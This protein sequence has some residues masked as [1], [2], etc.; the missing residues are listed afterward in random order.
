MIPHE[1]SL[2]QRYQNRPFVLLGV[3]VNSDRERAQRFE[4]EKHLPWRSW[5]DGSS[6]AI[7]KQWHVSGLP[8]VFL[9]DH[10]GVIRFAH[11]GS[12]DPAALDREIEQLVVAAEK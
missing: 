4:Q 3:Y 9:L 2:V 7:V 5:W 8:T 6:L 1:R 10:Q 11:P 12:P